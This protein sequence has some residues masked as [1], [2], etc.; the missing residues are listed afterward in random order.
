M[1]FKDTPE[2]AAFRTKARTWLEANAKRRTDSLY[3]GME[4]EKASLE[5]KD[6]YKKK[7]DA[8][9]ACLTWP[10]EYGGAGLTS[11]HEVVWTQEVANFVHAMHTLSLVSAIAVLL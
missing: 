5:A 9:L 8:G 6:W 10:K 7:A 11:L 4:G 3:L 1:D 2:L